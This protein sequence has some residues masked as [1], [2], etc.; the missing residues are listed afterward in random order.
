MGD[1]DMV[2]TLV[3]VGIDDIDGEL[4]LLSVGTELGCVEDDGCDDGSEDG[5]FEGWPLGTEVGVEVGATDAVGFVEIVGESD[6]LLEGLS[7]IEG[8]P[9][10]CVEVEGESV[11]VLLGL[12]DVDGELDG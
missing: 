12:R 7:D 1:I 6:G 8:T 2:G 9:V 3:I 5:W 4:L 11:G 10:G